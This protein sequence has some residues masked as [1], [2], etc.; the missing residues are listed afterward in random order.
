[1]ENQSTFV[2]NATQDRRRKRPDNAARSTGSPSKSPG[3]AHSDTGLKKTPRTSPDSI[4]ERQLESP[5][6]DGAITAID[7]YEAARYL[8]S[9][10][11]TPSI[12]LDDDT[13]SRLMALFM[14]RVCARV[15]NQTAVGF[16]AFLPSMVTK[17]ASSNE[18]SGLVFTCHA[19]SYA[20]I[21]NAYRTPEARSRRSLAYGKALQITNAALDDTIARVKDETLVSIWLLS[22]YEV[23][24]LLH[25]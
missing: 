16:L 19:I 14:S 1:V 15:N 22:M 9:L 12:G 17:A 2:Q 24:Q 11:Q 21:A 10:Y 7:E 5:T 18:E 23:F 8:G 13:N 4:D 20:F 6:P 25:H 3:S